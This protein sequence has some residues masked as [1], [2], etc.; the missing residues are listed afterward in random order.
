MHLF[1]TIFISVL[2]LSF[3]TQMWLSRRQSQHVLTHRK[4][5]PSAFRQS[6]SLDDHQ[7]AA[8]Y[9]L[10]Q[11]RL[12]H[13]ELIYGTLLLLAWTLGGGLAWLDNIWSSYQWSTIQT[14]I[15]FLI[16]V[17]LI[18]SILDLPFTIY[19]TF[20]LEQRFGFNRTTVKTFV[21]DLVKGAIIMLVIG[22]PF[23]WLVLWLMDSM[24]ELWWLYVWLAYMALSLTMLWLY[25]AVIAPLFNKF[26][27]LADDV[28]KQRIEA[29][30]SRC[31]F[32]SQGIFVMDGSRRSSHGNAY[33]TGIG[34]N[35]RIVFFDTLTDSL[36]HDEVEAVLAHELGHF[37]RQHVK[38]R[39]ALMAF[40]TFVSLAI[41]GWL[42]QKPW[43]YTALGATEASHHM[44]LMLFMMVSPAFTFMLTPIMSFYSRKHEFEA[45]DFAA[46]NSNAH[47]LITA[48]VKMYQ[49][50]AKTLTPDPVYS[51][52]YDSHPP[53]PIR[54]QH[55]GGMNE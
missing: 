35:K 33:F 40:M 1:T 14:G 13:I 15:V 48:L 9:T 46:E 22:I 25:P 50:N 52:F 27:P 30:L 5:V 44:A 34:K 54:I 17:S 4:Q 16:S 28:L 23:T 41:L 51:A 19:R 21:S 43:F 20:V 26:T 47:D 36:K 55:L 7:K 12:G 10:A 8:D 3:V 39:I 42:I 38:K 31:G 37:K 49:E 6:V 32:S 11:G 18:M 53:A 45:D 24:G 2:A 29:L